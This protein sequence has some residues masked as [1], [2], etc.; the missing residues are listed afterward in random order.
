MPAQGK[1]RTQKGQRSHGLRMRGGLV[2]ADQGAHRVAHE[3]GWP[4]HHL[5]E[6]P[7][8]QE[9]VGFHPGV[10]T[11]GRGTA[12]A[13]QVQ[14]IH[15][16]G[17]GEPRGDR[18]PAGMGGAQPVH[19]DDR[20]GID[21]SGRSIQWTGPPSSDQ[22]V[23][24]SGSADVLNVTGSLRVAVSHEPPSPNRPFISRRLLPRVGPP[25]LP[26]RPRRSRQRGSA[27]TRPGL[28]LRHRRC[29]SRSSTTAVRR[30][31]S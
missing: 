20:G 14:G 9:L 5:T 24:Y 22:C 27:G 7:V 8:Q 26:R 12:V 29:R 17:L 25:R 13:V 21:G 3:D 28:G 31:A 18:Q 30:T 6:E 15:G 16:P 10:A 19:R 1:C 4:T 2:K 23:R 11:R